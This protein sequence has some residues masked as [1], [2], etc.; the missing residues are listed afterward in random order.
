MAGNVTAF[1]PASLTIRPAL[2]RCNA[3]SGIPSAEH[4][5]Q[6]ANGSPGFN[7]LT[8]HATDAIS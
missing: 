5:L 6:I 2:L 8:V 1:D 4:V 7:R 3:L